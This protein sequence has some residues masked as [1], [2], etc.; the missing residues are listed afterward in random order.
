M[1][2][3]YG[4]RTEKARAKSPAVNSVAEQKYLCYDRKYFKNMRFGASAPCP[5]A[6]PTIKTRTAFPVKM[7][8][9]AVCRALKK[10]DTQKGSIE[11]ETKI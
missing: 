6:A 4:E 2:G 7:G 3:L 9:E 10:I 8:L 5:A 11:D 1:I